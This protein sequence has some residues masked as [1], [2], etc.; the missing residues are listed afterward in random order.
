MVLILNGSPQQNL[1][2]VLHPVPSSKLDYYNVTLSGVEISKVNGTN[3][4][5]VGPNPIPS[6]KQM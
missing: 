6:P 3:G 4:N 1:W 2:L 5:L